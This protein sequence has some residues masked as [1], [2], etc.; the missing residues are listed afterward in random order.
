MVF[1]GYS[2]AEHLAEG[3]S[4]FED[5]PHVPIHTHDAGFDIGCYQ[6]VAHEM[7]EELVC[8]LNT[9]SEIL[10]ANWL[11]YLAYHLDRPGVG[12]VGNTGSYESLHCL[13]PAIREF[14]NPHIRTNAF[15]IR[16]QLFSRIADRFDIRTKIDGW[17]FEC[18]PD[19]LS[20][21]VL[22]EGMQLLVIDRRG[23]AHHISH[24]QESGT[25]CTPNSAPLIGDDTY[26]K[27]LVDDP[28]GRRDKAASVWG[29]FRLLETH[30]PRRND[31][32]PVRSAYTDLPHRHSP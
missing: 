1:K 23:D 19:G 3:Q 24:W 2:D 16:R 10:C 12:L 5:L 20:Q 29:R 15:L 25:Y 27:Y 6:R 8:F 28:A 18:G 30:R 22:R 7:R 14:P 13:I 31:S 21:Q 32:E 17:M 26:R 9:K 11:R 4:Y